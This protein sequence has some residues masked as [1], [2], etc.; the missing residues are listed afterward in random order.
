MN[1]GEINFVQIVLLII[2]S[3]IFCFLLRISKSFIKLIRIMNI[4]KLL[5]K[6]SHLKT[7]ILILEFVLQNTYIFGRP[8]IIL[9]FNI[10]MIIN[11]IRF[12]MQFRDRQIWII[13]EIFSFILSYSGPLKSLAIFIFLFMCIRFAQM[14]TNEKMSLI[15]IKEY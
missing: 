15:K 4:G 12:L 9:L 5:S 14:P 7:R 1:S 10:M 13:I 6:F 3:S 11:C 2:P 8:R